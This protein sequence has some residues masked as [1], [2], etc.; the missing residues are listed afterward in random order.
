MVRRQPHHAASGERL[1]GLGNREEPDGRLR[2]ENQKW[3][4][5]RPG[6]EVLVG[7]ASR[8]CTY[9]A[10]AGKWW[11][12]RSVHTVRRPAAGIFPVHRRDQVESLLHMQW[13]RSL[14]SGTAEAPVVLEREAGRARDRVREREREREREHRTGILFEEPNPTGSR[15]RDL[16]GLARL[17]REF[18]LKNPTPPGAA[19]AT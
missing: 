11:I 5:A 13:D 4:E 16:I 2:K 9:N 14:I 10:R 18:Y 15:P 1:E 3:T 8:P 6:H 19:Q 17:A 12:T 7:V